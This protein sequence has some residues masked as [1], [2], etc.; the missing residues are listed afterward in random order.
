MAKEG[1]AF[2]I[3]GRIGVDNAALLKDLRESEKIAQA[4]R[5]R[6]AKIWESAKVPVTPG[7]AGGSG[8]SSVPPGTIFTGGRAGHAADSIFS[9]QGQRAAR[10]AELA[11][12]TRGGGPGGGPPAPPGGGGGGGGFGGLGGQ[13]AGLF[14]G[15]TRGLGTRS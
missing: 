13:G 4:S 9:P 15:V 11:R 3:L 14:R 6:L 2:E 1:N 12:A 10:A 8:G 5:D 7:R